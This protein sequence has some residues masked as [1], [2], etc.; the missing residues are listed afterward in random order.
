MV[1]PVSSYTSRIAAFTK[2]SP[3]STWPPGKV[4]PGQLLS[5][6][7]WTSTFPRPS[8]T[9]VRVVSSTLS[10]SRIFFHPLSRRLQ[11]DVI[12]GDLAALLKPEG[13]LHHGF[14]VKGL[15]LRREGRRR[16][17]YG[18]HGLLVHA[19]VKEEVQLV[20]PHRQDGVDG[21]KIS[22]P[23][24]GGVPVGVGEDDLPVHQG[25]VPRLHSVAVQVAD[26]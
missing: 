17:G 23:G 11:A 26:I 19:G 20:R 14:Q 7:S 12:Q 24:G 9:M 4:I 18:G 22:D 5:R 10:S 13:D 25:Q 2:D 16:D 6:R 1:S 8:V 21:G 15:P 3:G